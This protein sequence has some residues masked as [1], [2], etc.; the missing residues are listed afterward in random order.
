MT[1]IERIA[2]EVLGALFLVWGTVM[3]LEH[4]GAEQCRA[5]DSAAVTKQ[6]A[7]NAAQ[8]AD[9]V[10][11]I[12]IEAKTY[13]QTLAAPD[14]IDSPHVSLCHYSTSR[15]VPQAAA[16]RPVPDAAA[17]SRAQDP[18]NTGT[19]VGPPLVKVGVDVDAQVRG[20]QDYIAKVCL[21]P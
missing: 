9:D 3:Y 20:L 11:T 14:P 17:P 12:N 4:R 6:E 8:A 15:A 16:A 10:K 7:H 18:V 13:A 19:D 1:G 21:A 2:A 5:A